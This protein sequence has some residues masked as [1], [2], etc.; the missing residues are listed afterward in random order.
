MLTGM[1]IRYH[2]GFNY[3]WTG[4]SA[5]VILIGVIALPWF[6]F[7]IHSRYPMDFKALY[8]A[9][10][11]NT[12]PVIDLTTDRHIIA[13]LSP[14]CIHCRKAALKMHEMKLN[15]P[16]LPFYLIIGGTKSDLADF[17]KASNA[18]D[19][20]H[21]RLAQDPFIKYT[22]GIFPTILWVNN[23]TIEANTGYPELN[24][25]VIEKWMK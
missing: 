18:Q 2:T 3:N 13:F 6:L 10:S 19:I 12:P 4:I 7:P 14:S 25:K 9:D 16:S 22:G 15:N 5:S 23:G 20:P 21:S 1:L 17:W 24:Q 8:T 11:T